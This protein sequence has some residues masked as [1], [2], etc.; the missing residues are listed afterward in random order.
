MQPEVGRQVPLIQTERL[1][2][3]PLRYSD[4]AAIFAYAQD[5]EVARHTLW[6]PHTSVG[7]SQAFLDFVNDQYREFRMFVWGITRPPDDRVVG[8]IGLANYAPQHARAELGFALARTLWNQGI[9]TE[10]VVPVLRFGFTN[11]H[12]N[13]VE[14]FCKAA[15]VASARVI[16][17]SGLTFEGVLRQRDSIKGA[18]E[19]LKLYALLRQEWDAANQ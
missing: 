14:A 18:F 11:L 6:E 5:P 3:R 10:A 8:T 9:T 17:K 12:L 7:D 2:L 16:E 1:I 13:R 4:A 15:N 19:D